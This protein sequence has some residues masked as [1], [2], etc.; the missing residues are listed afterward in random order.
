LEG[1]GDGPQDPVPNENDRDIAIGFAKAYADA[2]GGKAEW[3]KGMKPFTSPEFLEGFQGID[4]QWIQADK[5]KD[6]VLMDDSTYNKSYNLIFESGKVEQ[7]QLTLAED[8]QTWIVSA[9]S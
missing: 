2:G 1:L 5:F 9:F 4:D 3:I 6:V 8:Y 7:V